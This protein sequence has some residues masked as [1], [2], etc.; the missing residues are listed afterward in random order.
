MTS[1][2]AAVLFLLPI[3]VAS[4]LPKSASA[5]EM[6]SLQN[7]SNHLSSSVIVAQKYGA[8][9]SWQRN[10]RRDRWDNRRDNDRDNDRRY[11]VRRV[12]VPGHWE[13]GFLGIGRRWVE[14][15]WEYHR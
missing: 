11:E 10:D 5:A 8:P 1:K 9:Y 12:W 6:T 15:R 3:G 14:G 13:S 2:I 4:L 7:N